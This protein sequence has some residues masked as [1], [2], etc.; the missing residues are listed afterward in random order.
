V[1]VTDSAHSRLWRLDPES[2]QPQAVR[3][4]R[5]LG[6]DRAEFYDVAIDYYANV[7]TSDR[8][9]R[10]HKFDRGLEPLL[11]IGK[12]GTGEH[13]FDEPRGI[14]LYRRFGQM[15]VAERAGAQYLWIGTD[16]FTPGRRLERAPGRL[17][18]H[19]AL[20]PHR[21]AGGVRLVDA[22]DAARRIQAPPGRRLACRAAAGFAPPAAGS[23]AS[24][25]PDHPRA[26]C[27]ASRAT[28]PSTRAGRTVDGAATAPR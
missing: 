12:R 25:R 1:A 8:G 13:E 22:P 2:G 14:G 9:G 23:C 27:C 11:S 7:Y 4:V 24:G 15:F 6:R 5:D 3:R 21:V 18:C 20:L 28:P 19:G 10:L 16:V 17:R 26:R